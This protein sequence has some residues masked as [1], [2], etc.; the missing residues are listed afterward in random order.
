MWIYTIS[1]YFL[2][3][4]PCDPA[5][6]LSGFCTGT[7]DSAEIYRDTSRQGALTV[8]AQAEAYKYILNPQNWK[9]ITN[10][11]LDSLQQQTP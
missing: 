8:K 1:L 5:E 2:A 6:P 4:T 7:T 3:F 10:L 9:V 11:K